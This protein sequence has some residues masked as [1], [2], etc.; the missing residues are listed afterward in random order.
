[1]PDWMLARSEG[2]DLAEALLEDTKK[3]RPDF[4]TPPALAKAV[5][6]NEPGRAPGLLA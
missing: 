2:A 4:P 3:Y 1:M 6:I 5:W